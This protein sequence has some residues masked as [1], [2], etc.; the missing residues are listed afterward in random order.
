[1]SLNTVEGPTRREVVL[2]V[3]HGSRDPEGAA[4]FQSFVENFSRAADDRPVRSCFLELTEPPILEEIE[5]CVAEGAE[6]ISLVPF[7]LLGAGHVKTDVAS[8]INLARTRFPQVDFRYGAPVG[9]HS[10][11]LEI[12]AERLA[13][14]EA[15]S[16][17]P[18]GISHADTAVLL[19]ERGSSDPDANSTVYKA[20]RLLWE[21]R[22]YGWVETAFIGI[23]TPK[24]P[25]AI[26][27]CIRLGARRVVV[28]PYFLFTGV[29]VKR[30]STIAEEKRQQYPDIE[31]AV[32]EHIGVHPRLAEI[33]LA[34]LDQIDR[35][36]VAMSCD[37]CKYRIKLTGFEDDYQAPQF[38]DHSHGL[39]GE[40]IY[41]G[42]GAKNG[43]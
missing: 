3:G 28:L 35:G 10:T 43:G 31:F 39:R 19:V 2:V 18:T 29:L 12:L 37:L 38:S 8:A 14:A 1:M 27:R 15:A 13:Q 9:L 7:F 5:R 42:R 32:G 34:Q 40:H 17:S 16:P 26:D 11:L 21:G 22:D 41:Q 36:T 30:I 20:A 33:G 4:E 24:V 23:T 6:R 25:E